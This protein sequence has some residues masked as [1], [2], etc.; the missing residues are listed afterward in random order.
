MH[1]DAAVASHLRH[2]WSRSAQAQPVEALT[3]RERQVLVLIAQGQA[4]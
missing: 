2:A 3:E 1:L 4:N